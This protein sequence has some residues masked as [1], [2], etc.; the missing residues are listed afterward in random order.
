MCG[1]FQAPL[2]L[3][4]IWGII[5]ILGYLHD[6]NFNFYEKNCQFIVWGPKLQAVWRY[7]GSA[8][9]PKMDQFEIFFIIH[10]TKSKMKG[11]LFYEKKCQLMYL[12]PYFAGR[13][14]KWGVCRS[15]QNG[16]ICNFFNFFSHKIRIKRGFV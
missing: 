11:G 10:C 12:R 7:R 1:K 5:Y 3:L 15:A 4:L 6:T 2:R 16:P 9:R 8:N 13:L 14:Q